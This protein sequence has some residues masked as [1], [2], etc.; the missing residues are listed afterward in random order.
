VAYP[1]CDRLHPQTASSRDRTRAVWRVI[2]P[3][4]RLFHVISDLEPVWHAF[5]A[6]QVAVSCG[7]A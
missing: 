3:P 2:N 7:A 1:Q 4:T 5:A 6:R